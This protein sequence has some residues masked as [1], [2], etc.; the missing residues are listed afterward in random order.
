[1][2]LE[3]AARTDVGRRKKKNEDS[4]GIFRED[5]PDLKLFQEGAFL[6]VA[7]GLGGHT[8]GEIASK[9]AVSIM[10]DML[11]EEPPEPPEDADDDRGPLP[12]IVAGM[13]KANDSINQTN[14][15]LMTT[16]RPM[17]TTLLAVLVIPKKVYIA[18]VGDSRCYHIRENE[19]ISKTEDHSWVDEQVKM[20]LMSKA[21]AETDA[22][23]NMVTRSVGTHPTIDVDTYVWHTVPGD[24]LLLCTDGLINMAKDTEILGEFRKGG[25]APE[26]AHRLINLANENGGK[27]NITALIVNISPSLPRLVFT[28]I[29][30]LWRKTRY[31]LLWLTLTFFI[32]A[33]CL[34][35]GFY[36]GLRTKP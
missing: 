15:D 16:G 31:P 27:D 18:N 8:A 1:M 30:S 11:K 17:G 22:R 34:A 3:I 26:I 32:G 7:D 14:R 29:R 9:L 36:L 33:L 10:R 23:R 19:F 25:T 28:R 2:R 4:F 5:M 6:C 35:A 20:G 21:E 24:T 12:V 13:K